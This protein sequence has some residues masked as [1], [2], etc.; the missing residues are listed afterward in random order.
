MIVPHSGKSIY[1]ISIP[2]SLIKLISGVLIG[3]VAITAIFAVYFSFS[4]RKTKVSCME[5]KKK[6]KDYDKL[7][8]E[9][10]YFTNK[11]KD[12]EEKM[13]CLEE[14]DNEL[15]K[16][17]KN[18]PALNKSLNPT[19]NLNN[20]NKTADETA[21]A[22]HVLAS[23]S[24][25]DREK[26][27]QELQKLEEEMPAREESLKELKDVVIERNRRASATPSIYPVNGR[28]SSR[29]GYRKSP[30]GKK[31]EFHDGLD[32]AAA[33]N[34]PVKATADGVVVFTGYQSGY[35]N[36]V[37]IK[38][39]YGLETSYCHNSTI[40]VK[41]GETVKKGQTIARVGNTGRSTGSHLHYMVKVNGILQDPE[42][43]VN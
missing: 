23:R 27:I 35:G 31:M 43:Y 10:E 14:L 42:N 34:T 4:Y 36:T 22:R 11:T 9:L 3:A 21:K 12:L 19:S 30:F 33:Y 5:Y 20:T 39:D 25:V 16:L 28:I 32:I 17:L 29:F 41:E 7:Q 38:H 1:S 40:E 13:Q 6:A 24:G 8:K 26:A 37:V 2:K 15:R 18:D